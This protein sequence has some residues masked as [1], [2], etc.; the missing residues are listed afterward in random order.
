MEAHLF[1]LVGG[2]IAGFVIGHALAA[3]LGIRSK[4]D[5]NVPSQKFIFTVAV[6]GA[7]GGAIVGI[8]F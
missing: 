8:D 1:G 2:G 4:E 7:I 3:L 5:Q 6:I